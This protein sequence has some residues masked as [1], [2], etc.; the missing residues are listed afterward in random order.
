MDLQVDAD[1]AY[2]NVPGRGEVV[3]IDYADAARVAR[4]LP[5][6]VAPDHLAE[7]GR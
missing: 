3:E 1:R 4:T 7:T 5:A 2:V 6:E